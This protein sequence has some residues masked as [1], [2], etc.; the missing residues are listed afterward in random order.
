MGSRGAQMGKLIDATELLHNYQND[1][2]WMNQSI[3]QP[4]NQSINQS[5]NQCVYVY[6]YFAACSANQQSTITLT[7]N[8]DTI[9]F[10]RRLPVN[11]TCQWIMTAPV[12][13]VYKIYLRGL[14]RSTSCHNDDYVRLYDGSRNTN[15]L[16][17]KF[18]CNDRVFNSYF[19]SS[20]RSLLLELTTGLFANTTIVKIWAKYQAHV[21]QGKYSPD[22]S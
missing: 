11:A 16:L 21:E 4:I 13:K 17:A 8:N 9:S 12:G 15:N 19:Y 20:G 14:L 6:L 7:E 3:N 22:R 10:I 1:C 5:I 2:Q 18:K